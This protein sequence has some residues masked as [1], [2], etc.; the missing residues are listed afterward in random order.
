MLIEGEHVT[1]YGNGGM[2]EYGD[3]SEV[4]TSAIVTDPDGEPEF[5]EKPTEDEFAGEQAPQNY[6]VSSLGGGIRH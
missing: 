1:Q 3:M 6:W 4:G 2:K 5:G